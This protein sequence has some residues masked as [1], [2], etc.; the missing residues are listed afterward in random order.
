MSTAATQHI[1]LRIDFHSIELD[2]PREQEAA[3]RN[4]GEQID[5]LYKGYQQKYPQLS[6]EKAW[7]YVALDVAVNLQLDIQTKA[8]KPVQ[9]LIE[10]LNKQVLE[11]KETI[12]RELQEPTKHE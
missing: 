7:L 1:V 9:D 3:Y 5:K 6:P 8:L 12:E 4:A 10:A 11:T 2:V